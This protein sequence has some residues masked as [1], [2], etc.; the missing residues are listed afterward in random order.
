MFNRQDDN[1]DAIAQSLARIEERLDKLEERLNQVAQVD[2]AWGL[3]HATQ[4]LENRENL[5]A[6]LGVAPGWLPPTRGW[7][8]SPDF[9]M[10]LVRLVAEIKPT[11]IVECGSGVTSIVFSRLLQGVEGATLLTLDH[12]EKF[13]QQTAALLAERGLPGSVTMN[14]AAAGMAP[15]AVG[16]DTIPWYQTEGMPWPDQIDLLCVDGP[17]MNSENRLARYPAFPLLHDRLSEK[18]VV[19]LDDAHRPGEQ[20]ILQRWLTEFPDWRVEM[21][22][23]EK[24]TAVLR[25]RNSKFPDT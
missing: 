4:Q 2:V 22:S 9:L 6:K 21:L 24:G 13:A 11:S 25:R 16:G 15:V 23:T 19:V 20:A 18:A 10:V 7:A 1:G 5:A 3:V 12:D 17:I 14:L 8:A